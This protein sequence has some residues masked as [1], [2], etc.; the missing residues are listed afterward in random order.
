M[1]NLVRL[2]AVGLVLAACSQPRAGCAIPTGPVGPQDCASLSKASWTIY[3]YDADVPVPVGHSRELNLSP[4]VDAECA[5]SV[6]FV[7][8]SIENPAVAEVAAKGPAYGGIAW[9]TGVTPGQ[10]AVAARIGFSDGT[11]KER[12]IP[13]RV[14]A[15]EAPPP[16]S[17]LIAEGSLDVGAPA[18]GQQVSGFISFTLPAAGNVDVTLDWVSPLNN[19]SL[20]LF[21]GVCSTVPCPGN[22][23][24]TARNDHVKPRVVSSRVAAGDY[25]IR[26]DNLGPGAEVCRYQVTRPRV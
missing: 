26:I 1:R 25:S 24:A 5:T 23:V 7:T 20:V 18:R 6:S 8:W 11:T 22:L 15:L 16:E 3:M 13:F 9:V 2:F 21:Q 19:V 12:S 17:I 4:H 10:T 14:N